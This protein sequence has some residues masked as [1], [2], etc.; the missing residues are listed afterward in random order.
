MRAKSFAKI[1]IFL[2]IV[3]TKDEYHNIVSRFIKVEDLY[4]EIE[5]VPGRFEKF[6]IQGCGIKR[7]DN[8]IY[9]AFTLLNDYTQN[10]QIID[11]FYHHK[12]VIKKNIPIGG[13][14][15][16][17]SSNGATFL[18]M[19]NQIIDLR[20]S[21]QDLLKIGSKIGSDIPFFML[22]FNSANVS[23][24]GE[25]VEEFKEEIPKIEL[26]FTNIHCDTAKVYKNYRKKFMKIFEVEFANELKKLPSKEILQKIEPIRANDLYKSAI[27]LYPDLEKFKNEWFLSGSGGTIFRLKD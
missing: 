16:G 27:D 11:F 17:G 9:K 1:N 15:G 25:I 3:G 20:L 26:K 13:G 18:K 2:K 4:D 24:V 12:V 10:P 6:T 7:E 22:G 19:C 23:G 8:I 14:L 21:T 5:F